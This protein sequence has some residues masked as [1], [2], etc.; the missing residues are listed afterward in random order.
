MQIVD[1]LKIDGIYYNS[2]VKSIFFY[3]GHQIQIVLLKAI[4]R[5]AVKSTVR[6]PKDKGT[7]LII[8]GT[9]RQPVR[10]TCL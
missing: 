9:L 10:Y 3:Y 7:H 2:D 8:S 4:V 6:L 5:E 1:F